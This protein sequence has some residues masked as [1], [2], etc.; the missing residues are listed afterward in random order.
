MLDH[1]QADRRFEILLLDGGIR[2]AN[3]E[4]LSGLV[5]NRR[6]AVLRFIR[7]KELLPGTL[8]ERAWTKTWNITIWYRFL[9]AALASFDR[10]LYLD[11]DVY[12]NDDIGKLWETDLSDF[13]LAAVADHAIRPG[14]PSLRDRRRLESYPSK[15]IRLPFYHGTWE[16]YFLR[17][18]GLSC[19]SY[20]RYFNSGCFFEP[21]PVRRRRIRRSHLREDGPALRL[22]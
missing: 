18:L 19:A 13:C 17:Y 9:V 21:P 22:S 7:M 8:Q 1:A 10:I 20:E 6:R 4:K 15:R 5:A 2:R 12:V 3:R 11:A 16:G 14:E